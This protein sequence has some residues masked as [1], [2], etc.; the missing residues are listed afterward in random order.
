MTKK[1]KK[2]RYS[3]VSDNGELYCQEYDTKVPALCHSAPE[4]YRYKKR[5]TASVAWSYIGIDAFM[6][7][8]L[9]SIVAYRDSGSTCITVAWLHMQFGLDIARKQKKQTL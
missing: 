9:P 6:L 4:C 1:C 2:C 8:L 5:V 3:Y 7:Y